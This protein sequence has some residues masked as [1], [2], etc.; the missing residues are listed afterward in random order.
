MGANAQMGLHLAHMALRLAE[1]AVLYT[2]GADDVHEA[3]KAALATDRHYN[4]GRV[5]LDNRAIAKFEMGT[6]SSS[7]VVITFSD[8]S[9]VEQ[10]FVVS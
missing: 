7:S 10:G 6:Q 9:A 2:N 8:G 1:S 4:G 3:M 5:T